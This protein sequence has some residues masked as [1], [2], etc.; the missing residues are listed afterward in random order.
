[1]IFSVFA[2]LHYKKGMYAVSVSDMEEILKK[3]HENQVDFI[4]HAGDLCNDYIGSPELINTYLKNKYNIT[5]YGVYGNHELESSGNSME[6]VTP[7]LTNAE[8]VV[9]GTKDGNIGDGSIGYYYF[10]K[11]GYRIICTD[12]NYSYNEEFSSWEHNKTASWGAPAGNKL[13]NSLGPEQ[14]IW[15]E[16]VLMDAA[17]KGIS[18]IVMSHA[19]FTDMW[20]QSLGDNPYK[21]LWHT[22]PDTEAVQKIFQKVNEIT[23]RTVIM[24]INGHYHTNR[25]AMKDNIVYFDVNTVINGS[26]LPD[27]APHYTEEHDFVLEDYDS[28]GEKCG[29]KVIPLSKL[30]QSSNTHYFESP[31]SA[32]VKIE[33]GGTIEIKGTKTKWRYGVVPDNANQGCMPEISDSHF[34]LDNV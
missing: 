1:M 31:L 4:I 29:E 5:A 3:A 24:S 11:E 13:T 33:D 17:E 22:S 19:S 28:N 34:V 8:N 9:W 23:P 32:I 16:N 15:L 25:V 27:M 21:Y 18:C 20:Y 6:V 14:L 26:W 12:T 2:D 30:W 7:L 10:E